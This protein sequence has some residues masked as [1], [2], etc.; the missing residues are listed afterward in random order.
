MTAIYVDADA[1]PVKDE[2][3]R[4]A[5]RHGLRLFIVSNGG[6]RPRAEPLVETVIVGEGLDAADDWIA[7]RAGP[8]DVVITNDVPL[9]ARAVAAGAR[10]LRPDG[11]PITEAG[12]GEVL[13]TRNLMTQL[14]EAGTV[15]GGPPPFSKR[16]RSRFLDA[17][18]TTVRAALKEG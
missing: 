6:I 3:V 15:T 10:V 18:E 11:T 9:A 12:V 14:R 1:C 13:A 17:M 8:G 16:D 7:G 4:V 2:A 5:T